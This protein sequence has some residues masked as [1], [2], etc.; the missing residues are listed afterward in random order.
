[1]TTSVEYQVIIAIAGAFVE[2]KAIKRV[3]YVRKEEF[4]TMDD[5]PPMPEDKAV[6]ITFEYV[7]AD[8]EY[9]NRKEN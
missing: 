4:I 6:R 9:P 7:P 2:S 3:S 5:Q 1:M 8:E